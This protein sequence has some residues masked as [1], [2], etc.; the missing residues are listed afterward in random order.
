MLLLPSELFKFLLFKQTHPC[1]DLEPGS[2]F[3]TRRPEAEEREYFG[4]T[5]L[6]LRKTEK[7][8]KISISQSKTTKKTDTSF[9]ATSYKMRDPKDPKENGMKGDKKDV[10][11]FFHFFFKI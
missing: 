1:S 8:Q 6:W 4:N 5:E 7:F 3:H 10:R 11:I 9:E 2:S